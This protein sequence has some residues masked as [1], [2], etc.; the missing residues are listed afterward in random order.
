MGYEEG[1]GIGCK[2]QGIIN[3][4]EVLERPRYLRL[5]YGKVELGESSKMGS[6]TLEAS[7][8]SSGH[9]KSLQE[10]F[11][12]GDGVSLLDCGSE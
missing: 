5:G 10:P 12:K 4:I 6:K 9:P 3:P 8:A 11:T 2:F 7:N 1:K